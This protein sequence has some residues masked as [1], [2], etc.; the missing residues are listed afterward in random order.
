MFPASYN[1]A[2]SRQY[3]AAQEQLEHKHG[4][5]VGCNFS[6]SFESKLSETALQESAF[7]IGA[8]LHFIENASGYQVSKAGSVSA[9]SGVALS[10]ECSTKLEL[11]KALTVPPERGVRFSAY[12]PSAS[13]NKMVTHFIVLLLAATARKFSFGSNP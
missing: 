2:T 3:A 6:E 12:G 7:T 1:K 11:I 9:S 5:V 10:D 4:L 13:Q 8:R